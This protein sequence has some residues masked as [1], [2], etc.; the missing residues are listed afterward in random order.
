[1]KN[2][3]FITILVCIAQC[4]PDDDLHH[5]IRF[6]NNTDYKIWVAKGVFLSDTVTNLP[7]SID[8]L[9]HSSD[10]LTYPGGFEELSNLSP[11]KEIIIIVRKSNPF[12]F[13]KRYI[14]SIDSLNILRWTVNYP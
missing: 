3:L 8:I 11:T 9:P 13:N 4:K 1:M 2:L 7:G 14:L 12:V 6:V 5:Q 10:N